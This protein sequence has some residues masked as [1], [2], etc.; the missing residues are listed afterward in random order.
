MIALVILPSQGSLTG[1]N[2]GNTAKNMLLIIYE[3]YKYGL[4]LLFRGREL[5]A[6]F[7]PASI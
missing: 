7:P 3:I 6:A 1:L 2:G 4:M 5:S